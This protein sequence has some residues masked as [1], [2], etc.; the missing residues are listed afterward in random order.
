MQTAEAT[1]CLALDSTESV[2]AVSPVAATAAC[3]VAS[4]ILEMIDID[5]GLS[6]EWKALV[7]SP[8]RTKCP[9]KANADVSFR[10]VAQDLL[11]TLKNSQV[12]EIEYNMKQQVS[13]FHQ[14]RHQ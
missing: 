3:I 10:I 6:D 2:E 5:K 14:I 4:T 12:M 13:D 7:A 8:V 9:H 1:A 11:F